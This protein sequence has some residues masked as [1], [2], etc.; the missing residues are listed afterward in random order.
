M[1]IMFKESDLK[2]CC[3]YIALKKTAG[4]KISQVMKDVEKMEMDD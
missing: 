2:L 1:K 4:Q 3:F